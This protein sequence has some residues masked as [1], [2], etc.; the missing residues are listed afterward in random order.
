LRFA[1]WFASAESL[2]RQALSA[3]WRARGDINHETLHIIEAELDEPEIMLSVD[4][5]RG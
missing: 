4:A 2:R 1:R 5:M 3:A